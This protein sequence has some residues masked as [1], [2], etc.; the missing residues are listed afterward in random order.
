MLIT[1]M[2]I[3]QSSINASFLMAA[4]SLMPEKKLFFPKPRP[5]WKS[6]DHKN[7]NRLKFSRV[8]I[9]P[10]HHFMKNQIEN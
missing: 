4:I 5:D 10:L 1:E 9:F 3:P 6:F 2:E 8:M 7:L